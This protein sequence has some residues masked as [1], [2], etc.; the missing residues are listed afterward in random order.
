MKTICVLGL[1]YIGLPTASLFATHGHR[2][3]GVD[4]NSEIVELLNAGKILI[5]E[6][7]LFT[8]AQAAVKSGKLS[9]SKTPETSDVYMICVPTPLTE[10]N[11]CDLSYVE[12]ATRSIVPL[13]KKGDLV[14]LESTSP[15]GTCRDVI[16]PMIEET[17][18]VAGTIWNWWKH[19]GPS[20][21]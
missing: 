20:R 7:G 8:L 4:V 6:P 21:P 18:F 14:I 2:V 9:A 15:P 11:N 1:G 3:T 19:N 12:D 5:E 17:G 13:L 10:D 16:A